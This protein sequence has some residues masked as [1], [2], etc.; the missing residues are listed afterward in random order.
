MIEGTENFNRLTTELYNIEQELH[1]A[2]KLL[3]KTKITLSATNESYGVLL[4]LNDDIRNDIKMKIHQLRK[5]RMFIN[6]ALSEADKLLERIESKLF[7]NPK[8][9]NHD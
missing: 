7:S 2:N 9:Q 3:E 4:E 5:R 8:Q 6:E 1:A